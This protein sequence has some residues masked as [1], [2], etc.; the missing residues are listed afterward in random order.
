MPGASRT[1]VA[2]RAAD[3]HWLSVLANDSACQAVRVD[4]LGLTAANFW[5]AGTAGP[6]TVSAAGLCAG[7]AQGPYR[8]PLRQ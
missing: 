3:R 2:A 6:L 7:P 5:Q 8:Y 1:A 4:R